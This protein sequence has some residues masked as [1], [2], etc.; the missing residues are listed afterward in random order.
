VLQ[1]G[2]RQ[3][4]FADARR[5][6][7]AEA[8]ARLGEIVGEPARVGDGAEQ[9]LVGIGDERLEITPPVTRRNPR[10]LQ[11]ACRQPLAPAVAAHDTARAS[12]LHRLPS[13]IVAKGAHRNADR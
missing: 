3:V 10:V 4:R 8:L 9:L 12:R 1:D 6:D 7:E 5:T 11:Q 2:D 13:R